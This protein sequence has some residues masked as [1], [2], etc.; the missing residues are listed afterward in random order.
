MPRHRDRYT[1]RP[2]TAWAGILLFLAAGS[3]QA[4]DLGPDNAYYGSN[5][6][7]AVYDWAGFYAGAHVG[8]GAGSAH[9]SDLGGFVGGVQAG[10]NMQTGQFVLGLE[11][12]IGVADI[13]RKRGSTSSSIDALGTLRARAGFTFDQFLLYGT[14]G[15]GFGQFTYETGGSRD[16]QWSAGWVLGIGA[17]AALSRKWTARIEAFHYDLGR[18]N[19]LISGDMIP[20]SV[21]ATV[22]RAGVNY[23]F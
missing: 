15:F 21:D 1:R 9:S 6:S 5:V 18:S 23:R 4:A 13:D 12:D 2:R 14:G 17:E 16:D 8:Y 11:S 7:S 22:L 10:Y 3:A 19:Y 20:I